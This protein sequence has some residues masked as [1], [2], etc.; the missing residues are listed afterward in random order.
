MKITGIITEY[1]PFHYGHLYHYQK[2][3]EITDSN[4]AICIMN[5][6]FT[7]R[8]LP[9]IT[10]KWSRAKMALQA[11][12]DLI[13][14]LPLVYGIR[15]ANFFAE[16]AV[17]LLANTNLVDDFVFGSES[18]QINSLIKIAKF[19]NQNNEKFAAEIKKFIK[20]GYSYPKAREKA[21]KTF[22]EKE[23]LI[24]AL[25]NPNN[26]LGIEYIRAVLKNN[27]NLEPLTIKR[28]SNNYHS[29]K[30]NGKF[31][32]GSALRQLIKNNEIN[33]LKS[34]VP[35]S[36]F[37]ILK[38]ELNK[39]KIPVTKNNLGYPLLSKL[40]MSSPQKLQHYAEINNG[41]ENRFFEAGL[42]SGNYQELIKNINTKSITQNRVQ[43]NLLHIL[44]GLTEKE[45]SEIDK[46]GP[47]YL[48]VLAFNKNGEKILAKLKKKSDLPLITKISDY[49]NE[50]NFS[51]TNPIKK[52]L[53]YE[54]MADDI[55]SLLYKSTEFRQGR[56]D[57][58]KKIIL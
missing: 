22:F 55:Y 46:T 50:I 26:I 3:K 17:T 21:F 25:K 58:Y 11:G 5:G 41:L 47:A 49:I 43:R 33:K 6:N 51:A 53:S 37:K 10:D 9:A 28:T 14:E 19:L 35:K 1:N 40:R 2:S 38:K 39:N 29:T 16:G 13:I 15:S 24:T 44:F 34:L 36:S 27:F 31:A 45:F 56:Q 23:K 18:G 4:A 12:V 42:Q 8:G 54:I 48:R 7:Q 20:S 57:F 30:V 52:Q 32:S